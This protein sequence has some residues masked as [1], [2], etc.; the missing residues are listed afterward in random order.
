MTALYK[1]RLDKNTLKG[2]IPSELGS[3]VAL[4]YLD[5]QRNA[6]TGPI[7]SELGMLRSLHYLDLQRNKTNR[8][9]TG[10]TSGRACSV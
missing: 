9:S 5:L 2:R 4:D 7:P 3:M 10:A 8:A 6:L 1:F